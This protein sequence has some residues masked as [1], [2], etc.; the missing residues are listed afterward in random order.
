MGSES[1]WLDSAPA[2]TGAQAG[3]LP[4]S[5]DVA[6]VGGGFTGLSAAR[7]LAMKGARVVVLEAGR[8]IGEASGRNG[9]QCNTG[10]AQDYAALSASLGAERAR[11]YYQAYERAVQSVVALVEQEGIGCDLKRNGKLKLAAKP[12]HYEGLART[13]ELIRREVDADVELLSAEQVRGEVDSAGFHGGLLQRN[14]VQM[15]VGR[16]GVGLAQAAA[17]HGAL[18]YQDCAVKGWQGN[19]GGYRL[20]TARGSLQARQILLATGACQH[21]DLGWYRR[22]I[23]PVGSFVVTTEVLPQALVERLLPHQRSYVTSRT[24]GNYFRL[25]PDNRLLFGGRARFAMSSPSSDA[26][27]GKV[28]QAAM[29]QMFPQLAG[30]GIDYC[31][32]GLVDMTSDRLPRAGER[33]GIYHAMGYSGHG[34]QMSVHMGQVMAEVMDGKASANPNPWQDLA[35]PAIPGHFGKPWFLPLVGA[36]YRFQ[37]YLH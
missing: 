34:V 12:L 30:V 35:W 6:I 17:R 7:A 33:N 8:V 24:I 27:S 3:A 32:G 9:G 10:V 19:S 29:V 37:D 26:K 16:F 36:Y 20:D 31:W 21:G 22:R 14:G 1:Y 15:H 28:L 2:F 18:I 13:C 5:V 23:V 25:T 11:A 4:D